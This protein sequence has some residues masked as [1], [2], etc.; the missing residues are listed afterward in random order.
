PP[1][2]LFRRARPGGQFNPESRKS[3]C[4]KLGQVLVQSPTAFPMVSRLWSCG[5]YRSECP[6]NCR[7]HCQLPPAGTVK[8]IC[9]SAVECVREEQ[10]EANCASR[11]CGLAG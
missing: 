5:I 3:E 8:W 1:L 11:E 10:L 9:R 7:S 2:P 6:V 4:R